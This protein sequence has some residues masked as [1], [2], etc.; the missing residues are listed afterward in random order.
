MIKS[1]NA[2]YSDPNRKHVPRRFP[3]WKIQ[4]W[5]ERNLA[6]KDIQHAYHDKDEAEAEARKLGKDRVRLMEI[7]DTRKRT[8]L[9]EL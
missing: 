2:R 7:T 3:Y 4:Y 5:V 8:P 1:R 6:W 9:E